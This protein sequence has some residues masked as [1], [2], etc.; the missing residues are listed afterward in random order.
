MYE[1]TK[2]Q[3]LSAGTAW[4]ERINTDYDSRSTLNLGSDRGSTPRSST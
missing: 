1:A 2:R 3:N 4:R